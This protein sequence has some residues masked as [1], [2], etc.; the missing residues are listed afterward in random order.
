M[1]RNKTSPIKIVIRQDTHVMY[2]NI[3]LQVKKPK[4]LYVKKAYINNLRDVCEY[5]FTC[6]VTSKII[7]E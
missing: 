2:V 5:K 1:M 3:K 4:K 7:Y 6:K